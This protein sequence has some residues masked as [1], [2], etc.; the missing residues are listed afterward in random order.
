MEETGRWELKKK[1]IFERN[2]KIGNF[3]FKKSILLI[4]FLILAASYL[5]ASSEK[6]ITGLFYIT[7]PSGNN[8]GILSGNNF[9]TLDKIFS[10]II[11]M[12]DGKWSVQADG[13]IKVSFPY[14]R[15]G[16]NG[17][18][19]ENGINTFYINPKFSDQMPIEQ[20]IRRNVKGSPLVIEKG[21]GHISISRKEIFIQREGVNT[22]IK[23]QGKKW[24][25]EHIFQKSRK[26]VK[27]RGIF[28][29]KGEMEINDKR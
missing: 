17:E 24:N 23:K 4:I 16:E 5:V 1:N 10:N 21:S 18:I 13:R 29:A 28:S 12:Q 9:D 8:F 7:K 11:G 25:M 3:S 6:V 20:E 26:T 22:V 2:L 15:R 14:I 19:I 27:Q